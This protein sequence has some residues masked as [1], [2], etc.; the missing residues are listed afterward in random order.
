MVKFE[1][2]RMNNKEIDHV[3]SKCLPSKNW[4]GIFP[5]DK[6]PFSICRNC[7]FGIICNTDSSQQKGEHWIAIFLPEYGV[8]EYFDSFGGPP[9][10]KIFSDFLSN[11]EYIYNSVQIQ[12]DDG[13]T[14]GHYCIFFLLCR[15]IGIRYYDIMSFFT[16]D[17]AINDQYVFEFVKNVDEKCKNTWV[18]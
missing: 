8:P 4:A 9:N 12:S 15:F 17:L 6:I 5:S 13:F 3:M 16:M 18:P 14:C 11:G 7:D 10:V 2:I 1:D